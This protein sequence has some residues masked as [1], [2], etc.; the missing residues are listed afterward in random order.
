EF[1][2]ESVVDR[3]IVNG[4]TEYYL[5]WEGYPHSENSWEPAENLDC[6]DLI[7]NYLESLKNAKKKEAKKR[8][9]TIPDTIPSKAKKFLEDDTEEQIGFERGLEPWKILGATD[10]PGHLMFLMQWKGTNLADLV[11]AKLANIRCPQVVIQFYEEHVAWHM[12]SPA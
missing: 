11:P 12:A 6:D 3:R 10:S 4:R 8:L 5:K 2:V 9:S 1:L 7:A